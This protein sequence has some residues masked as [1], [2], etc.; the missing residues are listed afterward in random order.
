MS[1]QGAI[2]S[3][4]FRPRVLTIYLGS[5]LR[6]RICQVQPRLRN[7]YLVGKH[8]HY[9]GSKYLGEASSEWSNDGGLQ[10][11]AYPLCGD[12]EWTH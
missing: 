5:V 2:S 1:F 10:C 4:T 11:A 7:L 8:S 12:T 9:V 3:E 6:F